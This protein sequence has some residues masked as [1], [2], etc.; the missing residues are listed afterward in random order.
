MALSRNR[1]CIKRDFCK[2]RDFCLAYPIL[3]FV[4][5]KS[6]RH[7]RTLSPHQ[8]NQSQELCESRGGCPG[9][10]VPNSPYGLCGRKAKTLNCLGVQEMCESRGG[11]PGLPVPRLCGRKAALNWNWFKWT[12][13]R[14]R[15]SEASPTSRRRIQCIPDTADVVRSNSTQP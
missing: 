10:P 15:S 13:S 1:T 12:V 14:E 3:Q 5:N 4:P 7:L 8:F 9:L 6:A 2:H 11:R